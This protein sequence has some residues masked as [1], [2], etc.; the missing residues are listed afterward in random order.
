MEQVGDDYY[1]KAQ[2]YLNKFNWWIFG[3]STSEKMSLA[4]DNY[5]LA[6]DQYKLCQLYDKAGDAY[7]NT[8]S[9]YYNRM[10]YAHAA[11]YYVKAIEMYKNI[12]NVMSESLLNIVIKIYTD[13]K[14]FDEAG[15]YTEMLIEIR[16]DQNLNYK[17][18]L[19]NK[20][21]NYYEMS[22]LNPNMIY[23]L[24]K[25]NDIVIHLC[26]YEQA[27]VYLNRLCEL[28]KE[29]ASQYFLS[30]DIL[31]LYIGD[32]IDCKNTLSSRIKNYPKYVDEEEYN[33]YILILTYY[34]HYD[35]ENFTSEV[36]KFKLNGWQKDL[37]LLISNRI[38]S[39]EY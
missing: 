38:V 19:Y 6:G 36:K 33:F 22:N 39:E 7:H 15:K 20:A 27:I 34:E 13:L 17:L 25:M 30:I 14:K 18:I 23:C 12:D 8:A 32:L 37:L 4:I 29:N 9:L 31:N 26:D 16:D 5:I 10:E 11:G 1:N 35:V 3:P 21:Y 28:H 24:E 2:K